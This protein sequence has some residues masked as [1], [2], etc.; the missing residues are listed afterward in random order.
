VVGEQK[1]DEVARGLEVAAVEEADPVRLREPSVIERAG[2][3]VDPLVLPLDRLHPLGAPGPAVGLSRGARAEA[4]GPIRRADARESGELRCDVALD[5]EMPEHPAG[6][7][8]PGKG[9][10]LEAILRKPLRE[11]A[12]ER[13]VLG[14]E[15]A[16]EVERL[17]HGNECTSVAVAPTTNG[18]PSTVLRINP[19][20][21]RGSVVVLGGSRC[22]PLRHDSDFSSRSSPRPSSRRSSS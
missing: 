4:Q 10:R 17:T 11:A 16:N 14:R 19:R 13:V 5:R 22:S 20:N 6:A 9:G 1:G 3:G 12:Q 8:L 21:D 18:V 15:G 7:I 2:G